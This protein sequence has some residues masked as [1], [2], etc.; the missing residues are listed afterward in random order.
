MEKLF[1]P[2]IVIS[3]LINSCT[4]PTLNKKLATEI[5]TMKYKY[6]KVLD[7]DM[8]CSDP[9]YA[10][11]VLN[12]GLEK[13][14]FVLVQRTQKLKDLGKPLIQFTNAAKP[15]LLIT[16]QEDEKY[17]IQKVKIADETFDEIET[18]IFENN[19][20]QARVNYSTKIKSTVFAS[21]LKSN[22]SKKHYTVYFVLTEAGWRIADKSDI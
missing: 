21:L 17:H 5:I 22:L 15:Y 13:K 11:K 20:K 19:S 18:I 6:P 4:N 12:A 10:Q 1:Y 2:I 7:Y 3:I 9:K 14:G 8:Y 16:T